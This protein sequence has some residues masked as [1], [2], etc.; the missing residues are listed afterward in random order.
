MLDS[1]LPARLIPPF[2]ALDDSMND[3]IKKEISGLIA[4][5]EKLAADAS[6]ADSNLPQNRVQELVQIAARGGYLISKL[7]GP[8]SHYMDMFKVPLKDPSFKSMHSNWHGHVSEIV[9]ILK[10][11]E[12]D[13]DSGMLL[14]LRSLLQAEIFTDFLEMSEH[15]LA[16][17][18]KDASAVLLGAV[19]EDSLR[20]IAEA[21]NISTVGANGRPLTI[22][23]INVALSKAGIYN[24]LVQK[25]ITSWANLRNDAAHGHFTKYDANQVKQMLLFVQKFCADYLK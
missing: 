2:D 7:Y 9:G 10:G 8:N 12:H 3:A 14:N 17:G 19:L 11:V 20:K 15:L 16:E 4:I 1:L 24:P 21:H 18:Y 5:G 13:I 25:Q 22:D 23:P 6:V